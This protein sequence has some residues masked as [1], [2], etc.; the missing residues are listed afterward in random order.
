M[1]P[2][3]Y[4][5]DDEDSVRDSL[6]ALLNAVGHQTQSFATASE[7]LSAL[8]EPDADRPQCLLVDIGL[9]GMSGLDLLSELNRREETIPTIVITG[10]GEEKFESIETEM[11]VIGYFQKP[12]DT[13]ELLN[14]ISET[15]ALAP[16]STS[17][18]V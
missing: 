17:P 13:S 3:V 12:F 14:T 9:P 16:Q 8:S 11:K 1:S 10:R 15:L 7:F 4:V 5:I 18:S 2:Q 6:I